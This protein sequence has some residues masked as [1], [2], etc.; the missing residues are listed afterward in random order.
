MSRLIYIKVQKGLNK[1]SNNQIIKALNKIGL[2]PLS[3]QRDYSVAGRVIKVLPL[4]R[5]DRKDVI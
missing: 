3:I 5:S 1:I 4:I 2:S